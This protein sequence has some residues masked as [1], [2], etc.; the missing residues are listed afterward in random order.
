[1]NIC[2]LCNY[3]S[4]NKNNFIRHCKSKI[5]LQ[6]EEYKYMCY[7]CNKQYGSVN[8]YKKHRNNHHTNKLKKNNN[9]EENSIHLINNKL[10]EVN[11]NINKSNE[12]VKHEINKSN[13]EVKTVVNKA[14]TKATCLIKYLME[15]HKSVQ[16]IKK[17]TDKECIKLLR[18]DYE[19][20]MKKPDDFFLE[21][22]LI[23]DHSRGRFAKNISK[24]ILNIVNHKKPKAQPI[25]N[26][27]ATRYNY[28]IKTTDEF[29]DEDKAGLKF[30]EYIIKL[31]R[32]YYKRLQN[33]K[34]RN[35]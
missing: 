2:N 9:I 33:K 17:I 24:S 14:I 1:M 5:H 12:Q 27:D 7:I 31:Y 34:N 13:E 4:T 30:A 10:D 22:I 16:P 35:C 26:T 8:A 19:C 21:Q 18:I 23:R 3:S 25:Y 15:H 32:C 28:V 20:P 29:W 11:N 6:N